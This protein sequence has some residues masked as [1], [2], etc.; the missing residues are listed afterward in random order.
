M[1]K[2]QRHITMKEPIDGYKSIIVTEYDIVWMCIDS[3]NKKWIDMIYDYNNCE[4]NDDSLIIRMISSNNVF[5]TP[6]EHW[7]FTR[8]IMIDLYKHIINEKCEEKRDMWV[9]N[10]NTIFENTNY[11]M[12][13]GLNIKSC[14]ISWV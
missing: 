6:L 4:L 5:I 3:S 7:I 1:N 11:D 8:A 10:L 2:T 13:L 12:W 9:D 14:H